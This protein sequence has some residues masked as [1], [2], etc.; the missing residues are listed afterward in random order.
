MDCIEAPDGKFSKALWPKYEMAPVSA[1][2]QD[3]LPA[4]DHNS[5][6]GDEAP[7]IRGK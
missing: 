3:G 5:R 1:A 4:V 2:Q 7:G 6:A